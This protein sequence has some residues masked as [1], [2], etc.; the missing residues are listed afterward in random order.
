M[1]SLDVHIEGIGWWSPGVADWSHAA[2]VLRAH[3]GWP[4]GGDAQPAAQ[5]LPP[6]ERRRAPEPVR[7]ACEVGAQACAMAAR[8]PADLAVVF[9]S[10]HGDL[11]ITDAMCAT[12]AADPFQLSPTRFHNS[13]HNAPAGYWTVA[14]RCQAASS[15]LSAWRGSFA[16]GLLEAAVETLAETAPVL[17]VACD[18]AARGPLAEVVDAARSF[19]AALVLAPTRGPRTLATLRLR[20]EVPADGAAD[21]PHASAL[22][23]LGVLARAEPA[24]VR[25]ADGATGA[26]AIEVA[27]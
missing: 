16:A 9:T 2:T 22:A 23:L 25:L 12:L 11:A 14:T 7:I 21:A 3:A 18:V 27:A 19:G 17:F 10:M 26:L 6:T 4:H 5:V 24:Q 20:R 8:D 13:V 1:E 15:A